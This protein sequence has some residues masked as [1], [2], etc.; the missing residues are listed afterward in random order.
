[1]GNRKEKMRVAVSQRY[2]IKLQNFQKGQKNRE[3]HFRRDNR[4][5]LSYV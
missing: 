2:N 5:N 4:N 1:M 3:R